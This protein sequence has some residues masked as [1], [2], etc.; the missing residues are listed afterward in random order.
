VQLEPGAEL[1]AAAQPKPRQQGEQLAA[2]G[3]LKSLAS[4]SLVQVGRAGGLWWSLGA[5]GV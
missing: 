3:A 4:F 2:L 5:A 1:A